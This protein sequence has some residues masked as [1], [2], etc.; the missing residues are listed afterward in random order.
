MEEGGRGGEGGR[1]G[2]RKGGS[3]V[4]TAGCARKLVG[5]FLLVTYLNPSHMRARNC[6]GKKREFYS[7]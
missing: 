6:V 5:R 4:I 2:R 1:E 3:T 7:W